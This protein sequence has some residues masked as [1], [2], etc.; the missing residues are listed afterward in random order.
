[1]VP[2]KTSTHYSKPPNLVTA[3]FVGQVR[4]ELIKEHESMQS[5]SWT[6]FLVVNEKKKTRGTWPFGPR[7][8]EGLTQQ[9]D[10]SQVTAN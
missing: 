4:L 5:R 9:S 7:R 1:M 10:T 3:F 2:L 8:F 6:G